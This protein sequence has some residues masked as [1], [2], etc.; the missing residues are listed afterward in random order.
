M[1]N[2]SFCNL[3]RLRPVTNWRTPFLGFAVLWVAASPAIA[4]VLLPVALLPGSTAWAIGFQPVNPEELKMT[5]EPQ[6][7]GAPAIILYREV[8]RDDRDLGSARENS[9]YR[10][11]IFT[12]EG[13]KWANV[14]IPFAKGVDNV[15]NIHAR[16][17]KPD[18]SVVEFDGKTFDKSIL[19]ARGFRI[20][21]KTFTLP[22]VEPG[23]IIEYSYELEGRLGFSS[24]WTL[25]EEL[26]T[27]SA[28]FH[29]KPFGGG[30]HLTVS[31]RKSWHLP[32]GVLPPV[33]EADSSV[34]LEAD[35]IPA[36]QI[37]D[38]MPPAD[39]L[40]FHV[41]FIYELAKAE[42]DPD[43]YW[44][45]VGEVRARQLENF[46]GK[47][48]GVD[49]AVAETTSSND[50]P[51]ANLRKIY[52][53][54]HQI[55]NTAYEL[56]KTT[57]EQKRENEKPDE[58]VEDVLKRGYGN[59]WQ[60]DWLFLSMVRTAGF[61]AYGCWV[62]SRAKY[63][64][65]PRTMQAEH[66]NEPAV[67]VK[68]D[69][70]DL[71]FNP[72]SPFAPYGML[73]WSETGTA[74]WRLEKDGGGWLDTPLPKSSESRLEHVAKLRLTEDGN[75]EGTVQV[76]YTGLEAVHDR[77]RA[78]N[79]DDVARK[80]FLDDQIKRQ[81][82]VPAEVELKKQPDWSDPEAPFVAEYKVS[83]PGWAS[84]AGKRT[85]IPAGVF[86]GIE[87][88]LFEHADRVHNVYIE[89]PY[90]KDDDVTIALP[91]L[92]EVGNVPAPV[93]KE[94]KVIGYSLNVENNKT[95][96]HLTRKLH[97]DFL[98]LDVKYYP[99]LR[100]FFQDVRTGDEQQILLQPAAASAGN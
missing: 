98:M 77:E 56:H 2:R 81:I 25:S 60:I 91:Q 68:L 54:V 82:P 6:A 61:D 41:D 5:S 35:N 43:V 28:N 89:Y 88:H 46:V 100:N 75:L 44:K 13:R 23:C 9:Y 14:E 62:S 21:A 33:T 63:F 87:K 12:E 52:A 48:K 7:P 31:L 47:A 1:N 92:W 76:T 59:T 85:L 11:K 90:E 53:R 66:L 93:N 20:E 83:I 22:A 69:G 74:A 27:K 40:K 18:G 95:A 94:G 97:W 38:F 15:K 64:F 73:N 8:D 32:P 19:K 24:R 86:T 70:Q 45:H 79:E 78:R 10:I 3:P 50:T 37:E 80:T 72:G 4:A 71:F 58:N 39:E 29:L 96:L 57:Q 67:L 17:I 99:A 26:F 16:T 51:E 36:F 84:S 65:S 34:S 55:R 30:S 49:Q 42:N